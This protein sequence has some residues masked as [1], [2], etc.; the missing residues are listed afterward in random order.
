MPTSFATMMMLATTATAAEEMKHKQN[1]LYNIGII[2]T[3]IQSCIPE[4]SI[5]LFNPS[6][7][8][9]QNS[10][11]N[12]DKRYS[13]LIESSFGT[14][15]ENK[16]RGTLRDSKAKAQRKSF[17]IWTN[18]TARPHCCGTEFIRYG[19]IFANSVLASR[20]RTGSASTGSASAGRICT[21]IF[22]AG[23]ISAPFG[24]AGYVPAPS[25]PA[26][27]VLAPSGGLAGYM[28]FYK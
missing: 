21:D 5:I 24:S 27:Y 25:G 15:Q 18:C 22:R 2:H 23:Y 7:I 10:M 17:Q 3:I 26:G 1:K 9:I 28:L 14:I 12:K 4:F 6:F 19:R 8:L 11:N 13:E 20:K 16:T